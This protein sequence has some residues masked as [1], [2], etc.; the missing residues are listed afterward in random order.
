M[1]NK[2]YFVTGGSGFIGANLVRELVKRKRDVYL[3]LRSGSDTWRINDILNKVNVVR[4]DLR[5]YKKL[6]KT[7]LDIKPNIIYH[8][9]AYGA[10]SYQDSAMKI[11]KTNVNGTLNLLNILKKIPIEL[12]INTGSS[13]E[14]G[15]K[16]RPMSE[17]D[18][19]EPN[20]YYAIAKSAQT[21]ICNY[22]ANTFN[23]PIV[24]LRPFSVYGPYEEPGRLMPNIM[25]AFYTDWV[26]KMVSKKEVRDFIYVEDYVG[27]CL[28][29]NNLKKFSGEIF[30]IGSGTQTN[31]L[32]LVVMFEQ[33]TGKKI[34]TMWNSF[35]NK[36]WDSTFWQADIKKASRLLKFRPTPL[37]QGLKKDWEWFK[38]NHNFYNGYR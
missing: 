12:L 13:S 33:L 35:K 3:L 11:I 9:A 28:K 6:E 27:V 10:Y 18:I 24:T 34:K 29:I 17:K 22:Y 26:L 30:N 2:K 1:I 31:F 20:S 5:N 25:S 14:Y 15:L 21:N 37:R 23:M 16:N 38:N 32:D 4:G 36:E 8:L 7:I 19:L